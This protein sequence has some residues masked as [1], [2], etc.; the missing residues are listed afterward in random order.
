MGAFFRMLA[1]SVAG[2]SL[3]VGCMSNANFNAR[4]ACKASCQERFNA[5][6]A[7]C[8]NGCKQCAARADNEA[9]WH[10]H[11]YKQ[12]QC[13]QGREVVRE[14]KSYR[15]PLQCRKTTCECPTDYRACAAAC[16]GKI[17]KRLVKAPAC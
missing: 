8:Q 6:N 17:P 1:C 12:E 11:E 4:V 16:S 7:V 13:V 5:C 9:A 2:F 15:D 10:Y 3:L 14:L